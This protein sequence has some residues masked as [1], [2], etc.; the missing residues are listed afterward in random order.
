MSSWLS[1]DTRI[2]YVPLLYDGQDVLVNEGNGCDYEEE[3]ECEGADMVARYVREHHEYC[4]CVIQ[5]RVVPIWE[6]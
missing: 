1:T 4:Y 6:S 3:A 5:K 2:E